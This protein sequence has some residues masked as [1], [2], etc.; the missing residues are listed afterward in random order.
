VTAAP[1]CGGGGVDLPDDQ[2]WTSEHFVFHTRNAEK[3]AC[4]D[5]LTLLEQHFATMQAYLGFA[6]PQERVV[7]YYKF[8]DRADLDAHSACGGGARCT[9]GSAIQSDSAFD[10][11][12]LIHAYLAPTGEPGPLMAEG[13]AVALSCQMP[14]RTRPSLPADA[15]FG[16]GDR[17][18]DL[19]TAG[20]WLASYLLD[21]FG[22][23]E[24][25]SVYGR[26]Q[27]GTA[28]ADADQIFGDVYGMS[29]ADLWAAA[30]VDDV[31]RNV[32]RW[33]C[34][35]PAISVGGGP[36]DTATGV[37]GQ[38]NVARTFSVPDGNLMISSDNVAF[39]VGDCGN[40]ANLP[41][42]GELGRAGAA[43][44]YRLPAGDYFLEHSN[45]PGTI[46]VAGADPTV[47]APACA[48]ASGGP[49]AA[50]DTVGVFVPRSLPAWFVPI[51]WSHSG[52]LAVI[53]NSGAGHAFLCPACGGDPSQCPV[54]PH[55]SL[56]SLANVNAVRLEGDPGV[57][58]SGFVLLLH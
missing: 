18:S 37:C 6:W 36:V 55:D 25:L 13:A 14:G 31:S 48:V 42:A 1:G 30:T 4:A 57:A 44:V 24:L 56:Q 19:Y 20:G 17:S 49:L 50:L 41:L 38:G 2:R 29:F 33:E 35:Q 10:P 53:A 46:T 54:A 7:D 16:L 15:V 40:R 51:P 28:A 39:L 11:H 5:I 58:M 23:E 3:D 47:L 22:P 32:C 43:A 12:E 9:S 34:A 8:V 21:E 26:L 52:S 45:Q 27:A